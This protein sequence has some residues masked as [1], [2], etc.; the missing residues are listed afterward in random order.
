MDDARDF[1]G[2]YAIAG[3]RRIWA[4]SIR[5]WRVVALVQ[6]A[7][8]AERASEIAIGDMRMQWWKDV[9]DMVRLPRP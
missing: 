7:L 4:T 6:L 9:L 3:L 2:P 5:L 1:A 8:V